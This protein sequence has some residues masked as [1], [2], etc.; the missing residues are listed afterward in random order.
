M[1]TGECLT[2]QRGEKS[3]VQQGSSWLGQ[4]RFERN[5]QLA[6]RF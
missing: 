5:P 6:A 1:L 3:Q 2:M 4:I